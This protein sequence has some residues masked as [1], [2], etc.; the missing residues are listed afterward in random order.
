VVNQ[1]GLLLTVAIDRSSGVAPAC[2]DQASLM[3]TQDRQ[4]DAFAH[5]G[6]DGPDTGNLRDMA[7][8]T[9]E[10]LMEMAVAL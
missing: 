6:G 9:A 2:E 3:T 4:D 5:A 8:F 1:T 10:K 7:G